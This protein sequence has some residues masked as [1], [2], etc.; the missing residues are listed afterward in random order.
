MYKGK[1]IAVVVPAYNEEELI[2]P[3]LQSIPDYVDRVFVIND[4][5]TDSTKETV[6]AFVGHDPR[7]LLVNKENG[8]VGSALKAGYRLS[9]DEGLDITAIMAGDNQMDPQYLPLLLDPIVE[10]VAEYSKGN[11][12]R[13]DGSA[14]GMSAWRYF[15]NNILT[16]LTKVSSG[17]WE[18]GDPQNGY[19]AISNSVFQKMQPEEIFG[20]YGY[21][22]DML[23]RLHM[24]GFRVVD[25]D[26]PARYGNEKS[27]IRYPVYI[28]KISKLLM[29]D[30]IMRL[31]YKKRDKTAL[32]LGLALLVCGAAS[33]SG[34]FLMT[35]NVD[36]FA[37]IHGYL[38][39]ASFSIALT[40]SILASFYF[41]LLVTGAVLLRR[42]GYRL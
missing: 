42:N 23:T 30:F 36:N 13:E 18:I 38:L 3:T 20:W 10:G 1:K 15:G 8:G 37:E 32:S 21:C 19:T 9:F 27:K 40:A 31:S 35:Q 6:E 11:R 22:N 29:L 39:T 12:L 14:K 25:V 16:F 33:V 17:L 24:Y 26:I 2:V 5:S 7:F 4:G 34:V 41:F 28:Y